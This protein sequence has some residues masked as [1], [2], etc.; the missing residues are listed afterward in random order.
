MVD[1][2]VMVVGGIARIEMGS[3]VHTQGSVT[4]V[5]PS[6][7]GNQKKAYKQSDS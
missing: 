3:V 5:G 2:S 4:V 7:A 1:P 6:D